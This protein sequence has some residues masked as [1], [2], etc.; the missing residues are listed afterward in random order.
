MEKANKRIIYEALLIHDVIL[1]ERNTYSRDEDYANYHSERSDTYSK[2]ENTLNRI[3]GFNGQT[4]DDLMKY[5]STLEL[6]ESQRRELAQFR[7]DPFIIKLIGDAAMVK[8]AELEKVLGVKIT[9][10]G[11]AFADQRGVSYA[12]KSEEQLE[13]ELDNHS[14]KLSQLLSTKAI[15]EEEYD[16]YTQTLNDIYNYYISSSKGELTVARDLSAHQIHA[17]KAKAD[18]KGVSFQEQL[19]EDNEKIIIESEELQELQNQGYNR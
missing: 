8:K 11:M 19:A 15:T 16:S 7:K 13:Q 1:R 10:Q 17:I 3:L 12:Q 18:D 4:M 5:V 6:S 14:T 9:N 2:L